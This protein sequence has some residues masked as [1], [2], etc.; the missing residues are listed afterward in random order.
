MQRVRREDRD[1]PLCETRLLYG[2]QNVVRDV[3]G[4]EAPA[5]LD[6]EL[7]EL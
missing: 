2:R 5:G 6:L 7:H 1:A 3:E 4:I